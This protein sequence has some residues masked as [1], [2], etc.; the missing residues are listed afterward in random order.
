VVFEFTILGYNDI[1][2]IVSWLEQ[3]VELTHDFLAA[4]AE[5][6]PF[7]LLQSTCSDQNHRPQK[8]IYISESLG[9]LELTL[10]H[11]NRSRRKMSDAIGLNTILSLN[12]C[13]IVLF[14]AECSPPFF[15]ICILTQQEKH[16][17]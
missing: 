5:P 8:K 14:L 7:I 4:K 6:E 13:Y 17:A 11:S 9:A 12:P 1:D 16:P 2:T 15:V 10:T 3:S